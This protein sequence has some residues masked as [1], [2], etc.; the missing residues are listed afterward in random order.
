MRKVLGNYIMEQKIIK[1]NKDLINIEE[2]NKK[3]EN[4]ILKLND[5]INEIN[6]LLVS[7]SNETKSNNSKLNNYLKYKDM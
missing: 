2:I 4:S 5:S 1:A 3:N 7:K 6:Y